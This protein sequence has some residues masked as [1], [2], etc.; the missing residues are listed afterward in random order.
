[1]KKIYFTI[2]I[3]FLSIFKSY[4][5]ENVTY[6]KP[7]QSILELFDYEKAPSVIMNKNHTFILYLYSNTYKTLDDLN[8]EEMKLG[9][10]RVNPKLNISSTITF[11]RNLKVQVINSSEIKQITGLPSNPKIAN[12]N[13]SPDDNKIAFTNSIS[14]GTELWYID[15]TTITAHKISEAKLNCN[16]G[17]PYTWQ[18]DSKSLLVKTL[19]SN[20]KAF[21]DGTKE[22][23]SGPTVSL[24][25]GSKAQNRTYQDLLKNKIDEQNFKTLITSE[26]LNIDLAGKEKLWKNADLYG[27]LNLS[28]D[29][30][31][32]LIST[33]QEPFSYIV[34]M[35]RFAINY[36]VYKIDG[37]LLKNIEKAPLTE[38]LP[39]GMMAVRKGKR[40]ISWR[41]DKPASL[42]Y[43]EALDNGDPEVKV[44]FRDELI[45]WEAPFTD[46][47]KSAVKVKQ[48]FEYV[49]WGNNENA[50]VYDGWWNTRNSKT[51][52]FNPSNNSI[53]PRI[54]FDRDEQ[55]AYGNPGDFETETNQFGKE[56]LAMNKKGEVYLIGEG[57]TAKG[58]FPFID[59]LNLKTLKKER[60]YQSKYTNKKETLSSILDKEKGIVLVR[61]ESPI[62]YPNYYIRSINSK[63]EPK[64][65]TT[66]KN[67]FTSLAKVHK[68]VIKYKRA[69]GLELSATM[70][71]PANYDKSKKEKLPM[72]MW[73][74]PAEFKSKNSAAQTT[75]N[76]NEFTFPYYG[77]FVYWV[78]KGYVVLDDASFPIVGE[79]EQE[80]NDTFLEQLVSNAKAAIDAVDS[81]GFVD[82]NRVAVGGHSYGAFMTANLLT[83]SNLFACGVARS[84]AYN[85][86]LTPFGFQNEERNYWEAQ[87][88]YNTMA[89]FNT[90]D[91]MK[92]P[93][94]LV[95]GEA[96]NNPGT[97][98]LQSERYFN[99]IKGLGGPAR[100]VILPK[101]SHGYVAKENLMHLLWEQDQWF[102]KYLKKN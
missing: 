96:D 99:A 64:A 29:G 60:I 20:R 68:E 92:T 72:L 69:D 102:E 15:M 24:S 49:I 2:S 14:N 33:Y 19:P 39:K 8:Q 91:K 85:R 3:C 48:R 74:Y 73:A 30:N 71:L 40:N 46:S 23:P 42:Y 35:N 100:L 89:P 88:V 57:F 5:Q 95:H 93:L 87:N 67:P 13:W 38:T 61:I 9:G 16:L 90:A 4:A 22:I 58:Q 47:P 12:L 50:I 65:I 25:N 41:A 6:Q 82:R 11:Y 45:T 59:K 94:L 44:D 56:V 52:L 18:K 63:S 79:G 7:P 37:T 26:I 17:S 28:P 62:E 54:I 27:G 31:Y 83:H 78:T 21:I 101:E 66:F 53:A 75:S 98:T 80:P 84:G 34:Q 55:D 36:D 43:V 81:L 1:M 97:F 51:Y 76:P 32:V 10:L 86:T 77:S 70:Y